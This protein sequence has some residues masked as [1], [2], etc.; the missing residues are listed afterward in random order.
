[1]DSYNL[2]IH[3]PND[4]T[5]RILIRTIHLYFFISSIIIQYYI[6]NVYLFNIDTSFHLIYTYNYYLVYFINTV[7]LLYMIS[8]IIYLPNIIIFMINL[9]DIILKSIGT[10]MN[11]T[12]I[13]EPEFQFLTF[14]IWNLLIILNIYI[15]FLFNRIKYNNQHYSLPGKSIRMI[16]DCS[17]CLQA[18]TNWTL[19]CNHTYHYICIN[20]WVNTSK[21]CPCCRYSLS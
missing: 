11:S 1:M 2:Y 21:T 15:L 18:N 3:P 5:Y 17:I 19:P 9:I 14:Y 7:N 8:N 10:I 4:I 12:V 16:N 20:K 13:M 6:S